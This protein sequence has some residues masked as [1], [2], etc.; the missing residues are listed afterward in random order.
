MK[1]ALRSR[2]SAHIMSAVVCGLDVHKETTYATV[3][4][5]NGHV[6]IR[7]KMPNEDIP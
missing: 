4:D 1:N 5:P 6:L 7:R 2:R 3:I